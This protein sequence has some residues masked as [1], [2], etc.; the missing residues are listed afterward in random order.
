MSEKTIAIF[1]LLVVCGVFM[2]MMYIA[3]IKTLNIKSKTVGDGQHGTARFATNKDINKAYT[4]VP[5]HP[6]EWRIKNPDNLPQGI[7]VGC[8]SS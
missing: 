4:T 5:Y 3:N 8:L 1:S 6:K 2:F 7:I